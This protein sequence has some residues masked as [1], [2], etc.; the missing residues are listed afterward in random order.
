MARL[1]DSSVQVLVRWLQAFEQNNR[2]I[3][4]GG[5]KLRAGR[6]A[7]TSAVNSPIF[8]NLRFLRGTE[9]WP[10]VVRGRCDYSDGECARSV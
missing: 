9:M 2:R 3:T 8:S 10:T 4:T 1:T 6:L 5:L 7:V